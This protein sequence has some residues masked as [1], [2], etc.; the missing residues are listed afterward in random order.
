MK[1]LVTSHT[2]IGGIARTTKQMREQILSNHK[3]DELVVINENREDKSEFRRRYRNTSVYSVP[4]PKGLHNFTSF[5]K[6][7]RHYKPVVDKMAEIIKAE[8]PDI[9]LIIGTFY[10]PWFLL[11]AARKAKAPFIIRYGGII[12]MEETKKIWLR[13]GRD[14]VNPKYSYVFPSTHSKETVEGIHQVKLP[15]S[16]V[17]HNGLP[18]EFFIKKKK[19][20][21][22]GKFKIGYVGRHYGVKNPEFCLALAD[23]LRLS[24]NS[25]IEMVSNYTGTCSKDGKKASRAVK[26]FLKAGIKLTPSMSTNKLAKFYQSK[27]LIISPSH[28]E[29][30]GYVPLEAIATGTPALINKTLGI[31]EVFTKLGL[32]EYIVDFK[33]VDNIVEKIDYIR[34]KQVII[35]GDVSRKLKKNY[36]FSSTMLQFFDTFKQVLN[37]S[38]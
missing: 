20:T 34:Q 36:S 32:D 14:F 30:Y 5:T 3:N 37:K 4:T 35:N 33:D 9:I 29:T 17:I 24:N 28:F 10:F 2:G 12:E 18:D 19:I 23:K 11:S 13:M 6:F 15:H 16:W 21:K 8:S 38:N 27:D 22:K 25:E 1:I 7:K 26:R 31:R